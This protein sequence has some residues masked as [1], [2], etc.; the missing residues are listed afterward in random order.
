M[1]ATTRLTGG[2]AVVTAALALTACGTTTEADAAKLSDCRTGS[3]K[4]TLVLLGEEKGGSR[5]DARLT[6]VNEGP[7]ACVFNGY[8][9]IEI[10]NGK[11]ESVDGAGH[12]HPASFPLDTKATVAVDLRYTP[13]GTKGADGWCVRQSEALVRAPHDSHPIVVPVLDRHRKPAVIDACGETL[14]L[15]PPHREPA[16]N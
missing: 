1:R 10:H 6:A 15:A 9:G 12:G 16:G 3:L 5:P 7:D 2:L 8:P 11:A 4:W 13:P 14:S